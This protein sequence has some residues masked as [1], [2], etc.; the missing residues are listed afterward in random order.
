MKKKSLWNSER[1]VEL[2]VVG[3]D[4][5]LCEYANTK[6]AEYAIDEGSTL[7]IDTHFQSKVVVE[8]EGNKRILG[9]KQARVI[10]TDKDEKRVAQL[11]PKESAKIVSIEGGKEEYKRLQALGLDIGKEITIESFL[12][13]GEDKIL[14]IEDEKVVHVSPT[15]PI[16]VKTEEGEKQL[17]F[18]KK[19]ETGTITLVAASHGE[20][21]M[22]DEKWIKEG[23]II[24]VLYIKDPKRMPL[25]V[26][27]KETG[28]KHIIG[29]G[30]AEKIFVE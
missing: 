27:V 5:Y 22:Y 9:F 3:F 12:P 6:L 4:E 15:K 25:M 20:E 16:L 1:G 18:M 28:K 7:I 13:E 24:K 30:L 10:V 21:E 26:M 2:K 19:G 11:A 17:G 29:E 14:K 23:S 8:V